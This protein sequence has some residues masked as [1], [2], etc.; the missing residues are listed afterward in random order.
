MFKVVRVRTDA[1]A[2]L[3]FRDWMKRFA[4][5]HARPLKLVS[6]TLIAS[7]AAAATTLGALIEPSAPDW[8]WK[9]AS[10]WFGAGLTT[11]LIGTRR[12]PL[13]AAFVG[14]VA[15]L[16]W[17]A[18]MLNPL[19]RGQPML[20]FQ[21]GVP[22]WIAHSMGRPGADRFVY[23]LQ[24]A[25]P[26]CSVVAF[27]VGPHLAAF[28]ALSMT[29]TP[30]WSRAR[31]LQLGLALA[32]CAW[33]AWC[34]PANIFGVAVWRGSTFC[35]TVSDCSTNSCGDMCYGIGPTKEYDLVEP[36][37]DSRVHCECIY[38]RCATISDLRSDR[39]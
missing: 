13:G 15:G 17:N 30:R 34:M 26:T 36:C 23:F 20:A 6:T 11:L 21:A 4:P 25:V 9:I 14:F 32:L 12:A 16:A 27:L 35:R 37:G 39:R 29:G 7:V 22:N 3:W 8:F 28:T 24:V 33:G 2:V 31:L 18:A 19:Y 10:V 1:A 38:S 5:A